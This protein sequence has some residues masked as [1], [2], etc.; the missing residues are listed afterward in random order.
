M[1]GADAPVG[2]DGSCRPTR[3]AG[4]PVADDGTFYFTDPRAR[5][6]LKVEYTCNFR[7]NKGAYK[8]LS[9]NLG[10]QKSPQI[11]NMR[12]LESSRIQT[13]TVIQ[14]DVSGLDT[15]DSSSLE[16]SVSGKESGG[17]A[18]AD[19]QYQT[20]M[21]AGSG[22]VIK[23]KEL[24]PGQSWIITADLKLIPEGTRLSRNNVEVS[25]LQVT[26]DPGSENPGDNEPIESVSYLQNWYQL[27][28]LLPVSKPLWPHLTPLIE[29]PVFPTTGDDCW[30]YA[31]SQFPLHAL[32]D[33]KYLKT[34]LNGQD[35]P[36]RQTEKELAI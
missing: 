15:W 14:V 28:P 22:W 6:G 36:A 11:T 24:Q 29:L 10:A 34:S 7:Y 26:P 33:N 3:V 2:D 23:L 12:E 13:G 21:I 30:R 1:Q 4:N 18:L 31:D 17:S 27:T 25:T 19:Y 35:L 20:Q 8:P 16:L 9:A 5:T 32:G